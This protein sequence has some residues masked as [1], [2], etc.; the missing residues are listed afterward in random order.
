M[1]N[2]IFTQRLGDS[3]F[4]CLDST[5]W[6]ALATIVALILGLYGI[7]GPPLRAW[8]RKPKLRLEIGKL[9]EHSELVGDVF[10]LRIPV[11][12]QRG[13][14]AAKEVEVFL[15]SIGEEHVEHPLQL[16]KYLPLRLLWCHG[17]SPI[18]DHVA[19][20]AYRLL[21][22]G[23]LTFTINSETGFVEAVMARL[24]EANPIVLGFRTEIVPNFEQLGLPVGSYTLGFL[25]ISKSTA[26]RQK[27]TLTVRN[28]LLEYGLPLSSYVH[29]NAA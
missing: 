9:A 26:E 8:I 19:G 24:N 23:R 6:T 29:I 12:N 1:L 14:R 17:E 2:F 27:I 10:V 13:R 7:S 22:L 15:E 5:A 18:C 21:D 25:I 28:Q 11:S 16:P 20:G 3:T 4:L